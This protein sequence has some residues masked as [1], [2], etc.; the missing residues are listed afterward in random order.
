MSLKV[1][2]LLCIIMLIC[3]HAII[4][5]QQTR[6]ISLILWHEKTPWE[7]VVGLCATIHTLKENA[8]L[9]SLSLKLHQG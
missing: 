7:M 3:L 8:L 9:K 1:H 6:L 4:V 2:C 5:K